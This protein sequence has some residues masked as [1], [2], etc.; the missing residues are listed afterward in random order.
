[1]LHGRVEKRVESA[2]PAVH[3]GSQQRGLKGDIGARAKFVFN[4]QAAILV[5]GSGHR[6]DDRL[7]DDASKDL[8]EAGDLVWLELHAFVEADSA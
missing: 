3:L 4:E 7:R 8:V 2:N 5:G 1:M 6:A